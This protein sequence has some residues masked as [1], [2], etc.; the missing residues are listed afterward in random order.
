MSAGAQRFFFPGACCYSP[1]VEQI[2]LGEGEGIV[3]DLINMHLVNM[4][5][6]SD[7]K[8]LLLFFSGLG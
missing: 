8:W 1:E 3:T 6:F 2:T 4:T 7:K 5:F